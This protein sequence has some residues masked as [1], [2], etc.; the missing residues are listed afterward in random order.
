MTTNR[1]DWIDTAKGIGILLVVWGHFYA[2]DT[3]KVIIYGFHMPLFLFLSGYLYKIQNMPFRLFLSKKCKQLLVPF[4]VF[5]IV[6]FFIVNGLILLAS[7]QLY[8]DPMTLFTQF[9]FLNGDVGFNSPLWFLVVLFG[10]EVIFYLF[11]HFVKKGK[12]IVVF[13]ILLFAFIFSLNEGARITFGIQILPLSWLFYYIGFKFRTWQIFNR[14]GQTWI[15][16]SLGVILYLSIVFAFNDREI[17][18]FRSNNLGNFFIF[19]V[20][21]MIGI[22]V[23]CL[24]CKKIGKSVLWGQFGQH[25]L[26]ILGTHYFFLILYA[27]VWAMIAGEAIDKAYPIYITLPLTIF[28]FVI[29]YVGF[30]LRVFTHR[31]PEKIKKRGELL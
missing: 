6:T 4:F 14:L 9:F 27:N 29:Y 22:I 18:G 16:I 28:A 2:S 12:W 19:I 3:L 13:T 11:M 1:I 5:Q 25:S 23:F 24:I 7:N 8:S 17:I 15:T 30:Q 26:L 21:A 10:V 20:G 31:S